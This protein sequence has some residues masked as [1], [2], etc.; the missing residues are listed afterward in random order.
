MDSIVQ[1]NDYMITTAMAVVSNVIDEQT[2]ESYTAQNKRIKFTDFLIAT[3]YA[4]TS[5][6]T[7]LVN[8]AC[9]NSIK[10]EDYNGCGTKQMTGSSTLTYS[11]TACSL[12][13]GQTVAKANNQVYLNGVNGG[14][15][16]FS[17]TNGGSTDYLGRSY[18]GGSALLRNA[19]SFSISIPGEHSGFLINGVP[20]ASVSIKTNSSITI[21]RGLSRA[22]RQLDGGALEISHN[23]KKF[24]MV[25]VPTN[26]RY[27]T[28][29]CYPVSGTLATTFSGSKTGSF[30]TTF[31][32]CGT[33]TVA[34]TDGSNS[35]AF[36][37]TYC[38]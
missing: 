18:Q 31:N 6:C 7:R 37:M 13:V 24:S 8:E 28:N 17:S 5:A 21:T 33:G 38:L 3:A 22:N 10:Y 32:G 12:D 11:S 4:D 16:F 30:V 9:S 23:I 15:I 35:T 25:L 27:K 34:N 29:C 20:Y 14:Q 26:V 36:T 1:S 19:D 2:G